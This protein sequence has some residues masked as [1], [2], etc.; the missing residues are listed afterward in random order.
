MGINISWSRSPLQ[1]ATNTTTADLSTITG[2]GAIISDSTFVTIETINN[3]VTISIES[4]PPIG[5]RFWDKLS[6]KRIGCVTVL[7]AGCVID[8]VSQVV[9]ATNAVLLDVTEPR[10][11]NLRLK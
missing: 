9:T 7:K 4:G 2:H 8:T 1:S 11:T 3:L 6:G 5:Q 10:V